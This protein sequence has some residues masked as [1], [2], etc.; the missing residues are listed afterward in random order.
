M[1]KFEN[2]KATPQINRL[3]KKSGCI[4]RS[5]EIPE[6]LT[7]TN[8]KLSPRLPKV[9]NDE[10]KTASG[11]ASGTSAALWYQT[12]SRIIPM[13]SPLP[14]KSSIHSQKNCNSNTSSVTKNTAIN[15]PMNAL[16][17]SLSSFL[18]INYEL[19][20]GACLLVAIFD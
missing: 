15:G 11:N 10:S 2:R 9:I 12:N 19:L 17:T 4:N 13:E 18:N 7:A 20:C 3:T 6:D 1:I 16:I 14:T 8:S 5:N